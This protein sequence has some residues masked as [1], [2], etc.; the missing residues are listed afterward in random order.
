[1][2]IP[3]RNGIIKFN[4]VQKPTRE[5]TLVEFQAQTFKIQLVLLNQIRHVSVS[6]CCYILSVKLFLL[7]VEQIAAEILKKKQPASPEQ[8]A[9]LKI[10]GFW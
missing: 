5:L 4:L 8:C 1:M 7:E 9:S 6:F 2:Q 10:C 3:R